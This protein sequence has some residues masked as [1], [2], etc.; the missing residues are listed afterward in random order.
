MQFVAESIFLDDRPGAPLRFMVEPNLTMIIRKRM[1]E[2]DPGEV[3]NVLRERI[4]ELFTLPRGEF[5]AIIFPSGPYEVPDEVGDARPLLVVMSYEST[6]VPAN[7]QAPPPDIADIFAHR[8][9]EGKPREL[10][11]NLVLVAADE[12]LIPDM[13]E[14]I[15][16]ALALTDL[17]KPEDQKDLADHQRATV[18]SEEQ[19]M[20]LNVAMGILQCYRHLL[21]P[22]NSPMPGTNLSL[23]H[24]II[25]LSGAGDSPG[26][27]QHQV[28]RVLHDQKK[29]LTGQD[30]PR[31]DSVGKSRKVTLHEPEGCRCGAR[32]AKISR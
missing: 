2:I 21:Y 1:S 6:T 22:S 12:R 25:E 17:L 5:N 31:L 15:R 14:N 23:G 28:I 26:N 4:R 30:D 13:R 8:G 32:Q 24:T 9:N 20:R 16:R 3:R 11:N 19:T 27:G 29:I 7:L 10:K 18:R